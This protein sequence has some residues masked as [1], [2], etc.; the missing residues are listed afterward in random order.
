MNRIPTVEKKEITIGNAR[1][2]CP[3]FSDQSTTPANE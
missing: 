2:A 1:F 3:A